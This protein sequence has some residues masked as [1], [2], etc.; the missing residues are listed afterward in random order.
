MAISLLDFGSYTAG[1]RLHTVAGEPVRE[2]AFTPTTRYPYD[3]NGTYP[4]EHAYVQYFVPARRRDAPPVVLL[5]GGGMTGTVWETTPDGRQGWLHGLLDE[6]YAV[7]VVDIVERG[8]A[9]WVPGLWAGEPVLRSMEEAWRLFRFGPPDGFAARTAYPRCRFPVEALEALARGFVPRWTSTTDAQVAAFTALLER[10]E[11]AS[12]VCHSQGGE[13]AFRAATAAPERVAVLVA[14]EPSGL[15]EEPLATALPVTLV[16]GDYL[17]V[18]DTWRGLRAR[19]DAF[20]ARRQAEGGR[21]ARIDLARDFP[22]TTHLP[23][24]DRG[25]RDMLAAIVEDAL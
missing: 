14:L 6:G 24:Q 19:W 2:I 21:I 8:R 23:M 13:I 10:L 1:G 15:P 3:P 20:A 5:H 4:V 17:D 25:A 22:G 9:G 16:T 7:H 18:D 12:V 11:T